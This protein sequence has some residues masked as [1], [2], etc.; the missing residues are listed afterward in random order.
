MEYDLFIAPNTRDL[1]EKEYY[2]SVVHADSVDMETLLIDTVGRGIMRKPEVE[3]AV[4]QFID[5]VASHLKK[6]ANVGIKGLGRLK[7]TLGSDGKITSS[8][9]P[10]SNRI[11]VKGVQFWP[12]KD[13]LDYMN[14]NQEF[15]RTQ[16]STQSAR[17]SADE[18]K[19]KL[20]TDWFKNRR[21]ITRKELETFAH[22]STSTAKN[23]IK[24]LIA[25]GFLK[26]TDSSR[27]VY[28]LVKPFDR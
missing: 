17:I 8:K 2:P 14:R 20:R 10:R 13:L 23:R 22:L 4:T 9:T 21:L 25:M 7:V 26:R 11:K 3:F 19:V 12:E 15:K 24:D 16:H 5:V 6:G 1:E 28:E 27:A 18:L